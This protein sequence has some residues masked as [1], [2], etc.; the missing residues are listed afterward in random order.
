[1]VAVP[2]LLICGLSGLA[3]LG[4]NSGSGTSG[5]EA[6]SLIWDDEHFYGDS[7]PVYPSRE[8]YSS[9][10]AVIHELYG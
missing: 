7:P 9:R 3:A 6:K 2:L 10:Q 5:L 8:Y 4:I 1:M